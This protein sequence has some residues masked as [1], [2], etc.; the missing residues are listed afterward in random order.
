MKHSSARPTEE[1]HCSFWVCRLS[2]LLS[3]YKPMEN[4]H[5]F[6]SYTKG[7]RACHQRD[8]ADPLGP[9]SGPGRDHDGPGRARHH[10]AAVLNP[11]RRYLR[12]L[13]LPAERIG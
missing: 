8:G 1:D 4:S 6:D 7:R 11:G 9:V 12:R 13:D 5:E 10:M 3:K 2:A